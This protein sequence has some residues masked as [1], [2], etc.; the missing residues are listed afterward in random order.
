MVRRYYDLPSLTALA[1]FEA[2]A[3]HLSFK[4][5][6][7]ELNVTP[8]AVSRQIKSLE[9]ELGL[10]LFERGKVGISL[11][12]PGQDLYAVL[13]SGFSK[14]SQVVRTMRLGDRPKIVT[15][16]CAEGLGS[17]W[18]MPRMSD[19][20]NRY[21]EISVDHLISNDT[22]DYKRAEVD[23]CLRYGLGSWHGES[24]ELLF[25]DI[26]YP[27]CGPD[28][29]QEHRYATARELP[30]LSLLHYNSRDPEWPGWDE[31]LRRA[32]VPHETLRGRKFSKYLAT[33]Q[34]AVANQG[35]A[36]GLH[37][38][39]RPLI[40]EGKLS[41]MTE[42]ELLAPGAWFVTWS[43]NKALSPATEVLRSWLLETSAE[44]RSKVRSS[45]ELA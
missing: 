32:G 26:M 36:I 35:I 30:E 2:S 21:P 16:A 42:L 1:I 5:A 29:L 43:D 17:M 10:T 4:L 14:V 45:G 27:V 3:R 23:L 11:T 22:R 24:A 20:W 28:Y 44:Q 8:S 25:R 37:E 6:A 33:I 13:A 34:A 40:D 31:V 9:E 39:I 19:F 41:R 12:T 7:S 38:F 18:L 15:L